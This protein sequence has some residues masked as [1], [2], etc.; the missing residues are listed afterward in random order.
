MLP[1]P[2]SFLLEEEAELP[3]PSRHGPPP[4]R[5]YPLSYPIPP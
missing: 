5:G 4:L 2:M 3:S 1:F